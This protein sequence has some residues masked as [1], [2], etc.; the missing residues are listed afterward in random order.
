MH[1]RNTSYT[2]YHQSAYALTEQEQDDFYHARGVSIQENGKY[3]LRLTD[4]SAPR[5]TH[6][7]PDQRTSIGVYTTPFEALAAYYE[8]RERIERSNYQT[9][10]MAQYNSIKSAENTVLL[11]QT[12]LTQARAKHPLDT[13]TEERFNDAIA[14]AKKALSKKQK[15]LTVIKRKRD[16]TLSTLEAKQQHYRDRYTK[17]LDN[18]MPSGNV[19]EY[20]AGLV[21]SDE[22]R[23]AT[24]SAVSALKEIPRLATTGEEIKALNEVIKHHQS[25]IG[26]LR[27]QITRLGRADRKQRKDIAKLI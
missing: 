19:I 14:D 13:D 10:V 20:T 9:K 16:N 27:A 26:E 22:T 24:L 6:N 3:R 23:A 21:L 18:L 8:A 1:P 25:K 2:Q 5:S 17:Y 4:T 7:K 15:A 12:A 11:R